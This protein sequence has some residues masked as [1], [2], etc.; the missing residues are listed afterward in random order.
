MTPIEVYHSAFQGELEFLLRSFLPS[1][2]TLPECAIST[3]KGTK[4]VDVAWS[5]DETFEK[6]KGLDNFRVDFLSVEVSILSER[7]SAR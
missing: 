7:S 5:S 1:G 3:K 6:I 4:V 2:R